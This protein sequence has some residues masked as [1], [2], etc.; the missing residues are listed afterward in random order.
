MK[1]KRSPKRHP[2]SLWSLT[3]IALALLL[4]SCSA[5]TTETTS[6]SP[7]GSAE[8]S[9]APTAGPGSERFRSLF[10]GQVGSYC[11]ES[12]AFAVAL[13]REEWFE[14]AERH[15]GCDPLADYEEMLIDWETE[16]G[17]AAWWRVEG[18]LGWDVAPDDVERAGDE[19]RVSAT[20]N[21][22]GEGDVCATALGQLVTFLAVDR[23]FLD[24]TARVVF[25][26]DGNEAGQV[27]LEP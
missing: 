8:P 15:H 26:I 27:K 3:A 6:P 24:G 11:E 19:V 22:P 17:V 20:S 7:T 9:P 4:S 14:V 21:G 16:F 23:A 12:P 1:A 18:C 5:N 2:S 25:I 10:S 13:T